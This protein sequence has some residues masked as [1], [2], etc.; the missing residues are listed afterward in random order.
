MYDSK[1]CY[2]C[3]ITE[4]FSV[5]H[6]QTFLKGHLVLHNNPWC[7]YFMYVYKVLFYYIKYFN[8]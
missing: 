6:K 1:G 7:T 3:D 8:M 2:E 5:A 4:L